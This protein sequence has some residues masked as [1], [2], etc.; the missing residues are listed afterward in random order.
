LRRYI[1]GAE[2]ASEKIIPRVKEL[3][4]DT[5]QHVRAALASVIMGLAPTLGKTQT[6]EQLLPIFLTLLKVGS[7]N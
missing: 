1:L 3:A 6:I 5:S 4:G 7:K 2:A